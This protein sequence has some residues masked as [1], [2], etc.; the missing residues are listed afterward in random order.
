MPKCV[1]DAVTTG[2]RLADSAAGLADYRGL[3]LGNTRHLPASDLKLA[4]AFMQH[5]R[6]NALALER[7]GNHVVVHIGARA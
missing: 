2:L 6:K 5:P 3:D 7:R 1:S 4:L